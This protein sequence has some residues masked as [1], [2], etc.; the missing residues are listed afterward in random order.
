MPDGDRLE[1][2]K[3][4]ATYL[5]RGVRTVQR[6]ERDGLPVRRHGT[7]GAVYAFKPEL[8]ECS[9]ADIHLS[10]AA[11]RRWVATPVWGLGPRKKNRLL[12]EKCN[13]VRAPLDR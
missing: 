1:G 3:E 9:V 10:L 4:I 8:G 13:G 12:S 11:T 6:W 2:W 5:R 7:G